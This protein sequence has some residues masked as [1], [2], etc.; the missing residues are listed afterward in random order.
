MREIPFV[1]NEV[2]ET[3]ELMVD[4]ENMMYQLRKSGQL[5]SQSLNYAEAC[6]DMCNIF[7]FLIGKELV[8]FCEPSS[9]L[10]KEGVYGM[11]GNHTWLEI[12]GVIIDATLLQFEKNAQKLNFIDSSFEEYFA[13][14][15]YTFED[16]IENSINIAS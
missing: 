6:Y 9:L 1:E 10:V 14:R 16:W 2:K 8:S 12:E 13:V 11:L 5:V 3:V 7:I 4:V 15:T